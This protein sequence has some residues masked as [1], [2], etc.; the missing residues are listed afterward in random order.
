MIEIRHTPEK[1]EISGHAN[2]AEP[3]K[4][5]VCAAV[6]TLA[7]TLAVSLEKLT[8]DSVGYDLEP[9]HMEIY[10]GTLSER[11]NYLIKSFFIGV[12]MVAEQYPD[13]VKV[14]ERGKN[15]IC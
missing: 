11:G 4:D 6:S 12:K 3:G 14:M 2:Y 13:Y 9:G 10:H 5:I 8:P 15:E 7:Q 1:I